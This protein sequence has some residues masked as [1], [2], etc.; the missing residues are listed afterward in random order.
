VHCDDFVI[1]LPLVEHLQHPNGLDLLI[2][3]G[4]GAVGELGM[5]LQLCTLQNEVKFTSYQSQ[6]CRQWNEGTLACV[7]CKRDCTAVS[8]VLGILYCAAAQT[9]CML[10]CCQ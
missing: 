2:G 8:P 9:Q 4:G 1:P 3:V 10:A 6:G 5:C 7:C